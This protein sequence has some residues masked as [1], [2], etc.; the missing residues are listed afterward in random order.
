MRMKIMRK[1]AFIALISLGGLL[2]GMDPVKKAAEP[3][4][5]LSLMDKALLYAARK[6]TLRGVN[7]ALKLGANPNAKNGEGRTALMLVLEAPRYQHVNSID[8]K[9]YYFSSKV[10]KNPQIIAA[11]M[12]ARA[13]CTMYSEVD[14]SSPLATVALGN[15]R[16]TAIPTVRCMLQNM[17]RSA[18]LENDPQYFLG[19]FIYN[20]LYGV[21]NV[22]P[23]DQPDTNTW[24]PVITEALEA[25]QDMT[26][27]I[28]PTKGNAYQL[29]QHAVLPRAS[30]LIAAFQQ[31]HGQEVRRVL[32]S[33]IGVAD[34]YPLIDECLYVQPQEG[35]ITPY[36][37][38]VLTT[39]SLSH[40][41]STE[42]IQEF[43]A[44][45]GDCFAA[46]DNKGI[47]MLQ[48]VV[49]KGNL[50]LTQ[51][52][53]PF[54]RWCIIEEP[55]ESIYQLA[56][57]H[58]HAQIVSHFKP[59]MDRGVCD[60]II[61]GES[62]RLI[63][64]INQG[65]CINKDRSSGLQRSILNLAV[66]RLSRQ[67]LTLQ[68]SRD[69]FET[70]KILLACGVAMEDINT[71]CEHETCLEFVIRGIAWNDLMPTAMK[72]LLYLGVNHKRPNSRTN[73]TPWEQACKYFQEGKEEYQKVMD[74]LK[75][76]A[77]VHESLTDEEKKEFA[78]IKK[79]R[80]AALAKMA[81]DEKIK[82][83]N[84]VA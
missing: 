75:S 30:Q 65:A 43:R 6:E 32:G 34:I 61:S 13:D 62:K 8:G 12:K 80:E 58:E 48:Y 52:L 31:K 57:T 22:G 18:E 45:G 53:A 63:E 11:L 76:S 66:N 70:I 55:I 60:A 14:K 3:K 9:D 16:E 1:I 23:G 25:G 40:A 41:E 82:K 33:S 84:V 68:E 21:I 81:L 38:W 49:K 7:L 56:L 42:R 67:N 83:S 73:L 51:W 77:S 26:L 59:F 72:L 37:Q 10:L 20:A 78:E 39:N 17:H 4:K 36:I 5:S 46:K 24:F 74:L 35:R 15:E 44:I 2:N 29:A 79:E 27:E 47:S 19:R 71:D 50:P 64:L 69:Y 54:D 28:C